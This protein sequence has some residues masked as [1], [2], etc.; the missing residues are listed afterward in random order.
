[1][2]CTRKRYPHLVSLFLSLS[3]SISLTLLATLS[4]FSGFGF[5]IFLAFLFARSLVWLIVCPSVC[6]FLNASGSYADTQIQRY[7]GSGQLVYKFG[8][9]WTRNKK[10]R[11]E[12]KLCPF[13]VCFY[14]QMQHMT[15]PGYGMCVCLGISGCVSGCIWV[16]LW[17][18]EWYLQVLE[19]IC[20]HSCSLSRGVLM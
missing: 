4:F 11:K 3:I 2:I 5:V 9:L 19:N 8:E 17:E 16:C 6:C 12:E 14:F 15:V 10:R 20:Q 18:S 1:M 7:S 13:A